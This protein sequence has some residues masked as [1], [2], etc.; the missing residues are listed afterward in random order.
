[1]KKFRALV[2]EDD[3][4]TLDSTK[5]RILDLGHECDGATDVYQANCLIRDNVYDYV[6][7]DME[8]PFRYGCEPSPDVGYQFLDTVRKRYPQLPV[9]V[10]TGKGDKYAELPSE[11]IFYGATDYFLKPAPKTG[12]HTLEG[13]IKKF[14]TDPAGVPNTPQK[15]LSC[16]DEGKTVIWKSTAKNGKIRTYVLKTGSMRCSILY[17]ILHHIPNDPVVTHEELMK[18]CDWSREMYY[19]NNRGIYKGPIRG[20]I[21]VLRKELGLGFTYTKFG[22]EVSQPEE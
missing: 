5:N 18:V 11:S 14:V 12:L 1:M 2:V 4:L 7:L 6:I 20:H 8:L 13:S 22:I 3:E 15:W 9:F 19:S 21:R 10:V 16:E 17:S